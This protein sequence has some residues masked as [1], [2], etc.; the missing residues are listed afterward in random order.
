VNIRHNFLLNFIKRPFSPIKTGKETAS[1]NYQK[2]DESFK[3]HENRFAFIKC[4][5]E[6]ANMKRRDFGYVVAA[7]LGGAVP[8]IDRQ[9]RQETEKRMAIELGMSEYLTVKGEEYEI[10]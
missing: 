3:R 4:N 7:S 5:T 10:S 8:E 1:L 6:I 9:L 2:K